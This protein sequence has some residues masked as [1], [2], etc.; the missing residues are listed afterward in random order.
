MQQI[1]ATLNTVVSDYVKT[2]EEPS[3]YWNLTHAVGKCPLINSIQINPTA[4]YAKDITRELANLL[5]GMIS[6][7]NTETQLVFKYPVSGSV[8]Y[9]NTTPKIGEFLSTFTMT[10]SE[11]RWV[12]PAVQ[13]ESI[14]IIYFRHTGHDI[15]RNFDYRDL[16]Y[17]KA[18]NENLTLEFNIPTE[19]QLLFRYT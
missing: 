15:F 19:G 12:I 8:S 9:S 3:V 17:S 4:T 13:S 1:P 18:Y 2:I 14:R 11:S 6:I 10:T 5:I 16:R 7:S